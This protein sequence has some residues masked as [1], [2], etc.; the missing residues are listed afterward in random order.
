MTSAAGS[1][2]SEKT[3][4]VARQERT[5]AARV[6]LSKGVNESFTTGFYGAKT[7]IPKNLEILLD[8]WRQ[9]V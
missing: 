3:P 5:F 2:R 9:V 7:T 4:R 1:L 6:R 8:N